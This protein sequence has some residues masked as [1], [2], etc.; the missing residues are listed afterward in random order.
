MAIARAHLAGD[1]D[2]LDALVRDHLVDHP[3]SR[4]AAWIATP[5]PTTGTDPQE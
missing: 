1:A 3:D 2:L 4:L 5:T